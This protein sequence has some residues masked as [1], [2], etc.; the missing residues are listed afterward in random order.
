LSQPIINLSHSEII[1]L[2]SG[3]KK[4]ELDLIYQGLVGELNRLAHKLT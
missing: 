4:L 1:Q 2:G 3:Q